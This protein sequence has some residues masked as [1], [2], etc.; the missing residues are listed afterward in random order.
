[1]KWLLISG[2]VYF[3]ALSIFHIFFWKLFNWTT[4]LRRISSLNRSVMEVM[5]LCLIVIFSHAAVMCVFFADDLLNT[6]L[7][8]AYLLGISFFLV[9]RA[10]LQVLFFKLRHP[11]SILLFIYFVIGA[12]LFGVPAM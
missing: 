9:F 4:E 2:A 11:F 6:R 1:M 5:N 3:V 12:V 10:V 7:G 8:S